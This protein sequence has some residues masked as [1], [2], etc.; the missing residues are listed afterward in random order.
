[1]LSYNMTPG[2]EDSR[3]FKC[4][5]KNCIDNDQI[6]RFSICVRSGYNG[7]SV[8]PVQQFLTPESYW[9]GNGKNKDGDR[10]L[11]C[12]MATTYDNEKQQCP[13]EYVCS[14]MS[15]YSNNDIIKH[16]FFTSSKVLTHFGYTRKTNVFHSRPDKK[17]I[18]FK[19]F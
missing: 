4:G 7:N 10:V 12:S 11:N 3:S 16:Y 8:N 1:M 6:D 15:E 18:I 2:I 13:L 19:K 9:T 17:K 5:E 14:N